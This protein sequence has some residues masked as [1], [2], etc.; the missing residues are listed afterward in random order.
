MTKKA[1]LVG[2]DHYYNGTSCL[3]GCVKDTQELTNLLETSYN[4]NT[5][6]NEANFSCNIV[7]SNANPNEPLITRIRLKEKIKTLFEDPE[8]DTVLFYFSGHGFENSLGGY[9]V[10]QDAE[11]Y[12]EGVSFNELMTYAN[13]A[14]NKKILMILDCCHSGNLGQITL[15][16]N[17]F[18][19]MR[20]GISIM[21]A[22]GAK[23]E[24]W[25]TEK[26]GVFTRLICNALKGGSADVFGNVTFF[27]L[28]RH[29][30][31][32]LGAWEQRPTL[33]TNLQKPV[34]LR[35][36][37]SKISKNIMVKMKN[38]FPNPNYQFQLDPEFEPTENHGKIQ[39]EDQFL[40]L[41]KLANNGLVQP[42]D[43][44]HMYYA[45]IRSKKCELTM[46]GKQ[47]WKLIKKNID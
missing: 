37:E 20:K 1:L 23:Q 36:V 26:G 39:K 11:S 21:S 25:D 47:Y 9:L 12:E 5:G 2:I 27:N 6:G 35:R 17:Q 18:A 28:Y 30:E 40:D 38:Y 15:R 13:N 29:T 33:K 24:S 19:N 45:A 22:S 4:E 3:N 42:I 46:L 10:T 8:A 41:Q 16:N 32:M 43:E 44:E 14:K 7:T 31:K 34:I